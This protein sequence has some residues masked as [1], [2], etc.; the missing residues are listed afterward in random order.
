MQWPPC[1]QVSS[2][3]MGRAAR[4]SRASLAHFAAWTSRLMTWRFGKPQKSSNFGHGI[5][6]Y[7]LHTRN[8]GTRWSTSALF[9]RRLPVWPQRRA[10]RRRSSRT[11]LLGAF[12]NCHAITQAQVQF[13]FVY[14]CRLRQDDRTGGD[15]SEVRL[16]GSPSHASAC[17][18]VRACK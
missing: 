8:R 5:S 18:R 7:S 2:V 15:R 1:D 14:H 4:R 13:A 12:Q 10:C 9:H 17:L 16:Q 3:S 6:R 11:S